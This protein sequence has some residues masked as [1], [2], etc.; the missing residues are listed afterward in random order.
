MKG[1]LRA[2]SP[3]ISWDWGTAYDLFASLHVLHHPDRF[4]LR[5]AWAAGVRSRLSSAHRST[6]EDAQDLFFPPVAWLYTLPS[7]KDA[8]TA[9]WALAQIPAAERLPAL[10]LNADNSPEYVNTLKD[11]AAHRSWN[12]LDMERVRSIYQQR[13]RTVQPKAV[14]NILDCWSHPDEFGESFLEALQA[15]QE[16]FFSEEE[17]RIRPFLQ[18]ALT[19]AQELARDLSFA[20]LVEQLTQGLEIAELAESTE[21]VFAPSYW[22]TPLVVYAHLDATRMLLLFGSRPADAALVPGEVVPDA[23]LRSLKALSDPTRL[24]ILR[25]LAVEPLTPS[26]LSTRLRLRAPTMIHHLN[27][28][29]LAG[30]VHLSLDKQGERRYAI[31]TE[32]VAETF[33]ALQ[34]FLITEDLP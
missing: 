33:D 26:Q 25:Y 13:G 16:V 23:M 24:R 27:N 9:L 2:P 15:Y 21:V 10:A 30:L 4:G 7:P 18:S 8:A 19:Q 12:D 29:R 14:V 20:R 5:G 11:V 17:R 6:L 1:D 32:R 31:R 3:M 22:T 28:L 34:N